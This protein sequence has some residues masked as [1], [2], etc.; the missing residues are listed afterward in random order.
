M[1]AWLGTKE[2]YD[3]GIEVF[4]SEGFFLSW[5]LK[6]HDSFDGKPPIYSVYDK[7][8]QQKIKE[9]LQNIARGD[10]S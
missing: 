9:E 6:G 4:G 5:C 8:G 3:L 7:E 10:L 1:I 2:I